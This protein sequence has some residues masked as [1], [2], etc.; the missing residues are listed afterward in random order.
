MEQVP[1]PVAFL[2][3]YSPFAGFE[4]VEQVRDAAEALR[5]VGVLHVSST[6]YGGGVAE[7]LHSIVPLMRDVGLRADWLVMDRDDEFFTI[8]KII[9]NA[10]Q[11]MGAAWVPEM[12]GKYMECNRSCA[13]SIP[14]GYDFTIVHDPQPAAIP[15]FLAES[16]ARAGH[17]IWRCHIDISDPVREA[18]EF[19]SS[20]LGHYDAAIFTS[21]AYAPTDIDVPIAIIP[22][23]IDPTSPKNIALGLEVAQSVVARYG[24]DPNRPLLLQ[25]SRFDPWK[26][27]IGVIDAYEIAR[28]EFS[29]L[30]LVLIGSMAADDPEG[31]HYYKKA[32][33]RAEGVPDVHLLTNANGIGNIGVNAFQVASSVVLQKSLRE[34]FGLTVSEALWKSKAVVAGN[35]GGIPLQVEDGVSGFLVDSIEECADRIAVLL[36]EPDTRERMGLAGRAKVLERFLTPRHLLDY[37]QLFSQ[38]AGGA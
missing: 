29:D 20:R 17:W 1:L 14:R 31:F 8:T 28:E 34:G 36:R 9:H 3:D 2:D 15:G 22:P 32:S 35:V 13:G 33:E 37:L 7:L 5:G 4:A 18:W 26:D 27:P 11:G 10:L 12:A 25:V 23:S 16:S 6:P 21:E 19:I 38:L 24:V 30:Q